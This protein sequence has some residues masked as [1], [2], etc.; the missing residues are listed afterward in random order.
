VELQLPDLLAHRVVWLW[1][2]AQQADLLQRAE[3]LQ[4]AVVASRLVL[5]AFAYL[6]SAPAY[7]PDQ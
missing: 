7:T 4:P 6:P 2:L 3:L 1:R 5:L